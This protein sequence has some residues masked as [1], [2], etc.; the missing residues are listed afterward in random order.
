MHSLEI[1]QVLNNPELRQEV[2]ALT[3]ERKKYFRRKALYRAAI[4]KFARSVETALF[5]E[6]DED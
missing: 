5:D 3:L 2:T 4:D 6:V 1:I